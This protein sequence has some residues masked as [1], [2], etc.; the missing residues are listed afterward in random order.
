MKIEQVS[1]YETLNATELGCDLADMQSDIT[2]LVDRNY[3][4]EELIIRPRII[5]N[6]GPNLTQ[7]GDDTPS[8]A[9]RDRYGMPTRSLS[10][11]HLLYQLIRYD[12][13]R[14]SSGPIEV[15]GH[16]EYD[17]ADLFV[18]FSEIN[19]RHIDT[20]HGFWGTISE[21]TPVGPSIVFYS[22]GN[23]NVSIRLSESIS[24]EISTRYNHVDLESVSDIDM[25]VFGELRSS[26]GSQYIEIVDPNHFT[27]ILM[28]N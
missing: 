8:Y 11:E 13:F 22:G 18:N 17:V 25:L 27:L 1:K 19:Q 24:D 23:N 12:A 7:S 28:R 21:I 14:E 4:D 3:D 2:V 15:P 16:G 20:F 10:L 9:G 5:V 26:R 6:F